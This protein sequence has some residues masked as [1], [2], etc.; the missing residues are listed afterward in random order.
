MSS[1]N[2][3][4]DAVPVVDDPDVVLPVVVIHNNKEAPDSCSSTT[5]SDD[6][7]GNSR[8]PLLHYV[9]L[10]SA[11]NHVNRSVEAGD[12]REAGNHITS[13]N[14]TNTFN[15]R[16]T[17]STLGKVVLNAEST[18]LELA[19][20]EYG[21]ALGSAAAFARKFEAPHINL[22]QREQIPL[23]CLGHA[24]GR[25]SVHVLSSST[26]SPV[27]L[28]PSLCYVSET[29][30][31]AAKR[32]T[33]QTLSLGELQS[34]V[35]DE[36]THAV[37]AN[38]N[39]QQQQ[40]QQFQQQRQVSQPLFI[41]DV[42]MDAS[43]TLLAALN[44]GNMLG[45]FSVKYRLVWTKGDTDDTNATSEA[46][47]AATDSSIP[48]TITTTTTSHVPAT[49]SVSETD[50]SA[51]RT[52]SSNPFSGLFSAFKGQRQPEEQPAP[53]PQTERSQQD[54][55]APLSDA[56]PPNVSS[57]V[58]TLA[59]A[60]ISL[61]HK[62][63]YPS[64]F[65]V[66]SCLVLDPASAHKRELSVVV[67]FRSGRLLLTRK[68]GMFVQR[69]VDSVLYQGVQVANENED[70]ESAHETYAGIEALT[71]RGSLLAWA[72]ASGIRIMDMDTLT[73]LAHVDRPTG[74]K[75]SLYPTL[76]DLKPHLVF[77]TAETLLC[78]WGDCLLS[79]QVREV[80]SGLGAPAAARRQLMSTSN[81]SS[82]TSLSS[83]GVDVPAEGVADT[84]L[85]P[86]PQSAPSSPAQ[87]QYG[88]AGS[89]H[90]RIVE[91]TM[92]WQL[93]CVAI[94]V[95]PMDDDHVTVL[96]IVPPPEHEE[97][98]MYASVDEESPFNET[99]VQIIS[100]S[101]GDVIYADLVPLRKTILPAQNCNV[102]GTL[103]DGSHHNSVESVL[104]YNLMST[105]CFPKMD[106]AKEQKEEQHRLQ[107]IDD[108]DLGIFSMGS[109][110]TYID[111]HLKWR[112]E[113]SLFDHDNLQ[114]EADDHVAESG[115]VDSDD[116]GII[117]Q[118]YA[119]NGETQSAKK[120]VL[121]PCMVF[122]SEADVVMARLHDVEDAISYALTNRKTGWALHRALTHARQLRR[123][124][125]RTLIDEYFRAL[126]RIP[127]EADGSDEIRHLEKN[128]EQK[129]TH[130]SLR[131]MKLAAEAMPILFGGDVSM[132][133]KW[134][135]DIE[136]IPGALF[137]A[138]KFV[139]VRDPVLPKEVYGSILQKM[140]LQ[141]E[142]MEQGRLA[143]EAAGHFLDTL[144]AWGSISV[145]K[146]F[147]KLFQYE[148]MTDSRIAAPLR[149]M[150]DSL[151]RRQTQ[152]AACYLQIQCPSASELEQGGEV[153]ENLVLNDTIDALY[154]IDSMTTFVIS[155]VGEDK[156][157]ERP[158]LSNDSDG[159]VSMEALVRLKMMNGSFDDA[160]RYYLMI[161]SHYSTASLDD[162][163]EEA[164]ISVNL[165]SWADRRP[166]TNR[167]SYTHVLSIIESLH[168]HQCLLDLQFIAIG[169]MPP[170]FALLQLVG[171]DSWGDFL[172]ENC[173]SPQYSAIRT[174]STSK[175]ESSGSERRGTLPLDFVSK[176]LESRPVLLHWYL[177]TVFTR[178]PEVYVRFPTTATPPEEIIRLHRKHIELYI[179]F[180]GL[181][182]NSSSIFTSV[183]AFRVPDT[184][185]PLLNFL[186][187][188]LPM[189]A[190]SATEVAKKIE[191]ER[192]G[193]DGNSHTFALELAYIME[194]FGGD[195]EDEALIILDLYLKGAN[196]LMLAVSFAERSRLYSSILWKQLI[197]FCLKNV[198][199]ESKEKQ[200][201]SN[202]GSLFG[203]L[204]EAAALSGGDLANL[205]SQ[206]PPNMAIDGLRPRLVTAVTD[207]RLKVEIGEKAAK[208]S[209]N[210]RRAL[211]SEA[212]CRLKKGQRV[213]LGYHVNVT[214]EDKQEKTSSIAASIKAE[215]PSKSSFQRKPLTPPK[216]HH[217]FSLSLAIR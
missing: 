155:R 212:D 38:G 128:A 94:G 11:E 17:A 129:Q 109:K 147:I 194:H 74:A 92:A 27:L 152:S 47:A 93:D 82:N 185:T 213:I 178:K 26:V 173:V 66:P 159:K 192:K 52:R 72:D 163:E 154:D 50:P 57:L 12:A 32:L 123:Y 204:L 64:S 209:A 177:H 148:C 205:I 81:V 201:H 189:G 83:D 144:I 207:Y 114:N 183:E 106:N 68:R 131:R 168:L 164:L 1:D 124:D 146:R 86:S 35:A 121:P 95:A 176:Q 167:A 18:P 71:W 119:A 48:A 60:S 181:N 137:L 40:V 87:P 180:A 101:T 54:A 30:Q 153:R 156:S 105:F 132:W 4:T 195:S 78:G 102:G 41:V 28:V 103:S 149:A 22:Y 112:L 215:S 91:C 127:H 104:G 16:L 45:V 210:D 33:E 39:A 13:A 49:A 191:I 198:G 203:S 166:S 136:L 19:E 157:P 161:G 24:S 143:E 170:L 29:Q 171:L 199:N 89:R 118:P 7:D 138:R 141:V 202:D 158:A 79:L 6:D 37:A 56:H 25:L 113:M 76:A 20:L 23:L 214:L 172:I 134:M 145:L 62:I 85:S 133:T 99:E 59:F 100:R 80:K 111:P 193:G 43:G 151:L 125:I 77:E 69:R 117:F 98:E 188:V 31:V 65:G 58:P 122:A 10:F 186:K 182:R 120:E 67:G 142:Q 46:V 70:D 107:Q 21:D 2:E 36:T 190:L 160:L 196:S 75:P 175:I 42:S 110:T 61:A 9:R 8:M 51:R 14:D 96:G 211:R 187:V 53:A 169:G 116:Y 130:L 140:L 88:P 197:D 84:S 162:M 150:E 3:E 108:A 139:P 135:H 115:S 5:S 15:S 126:L 200:I 73:R 179:R 184:S 90:R 165:V 34:L 206:I 217:R 208:I 44:R 55:T 97:E 63:R 216:D 174:A